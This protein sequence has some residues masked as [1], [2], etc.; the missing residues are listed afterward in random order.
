MKWRKIDP[1]KDIVDCII[2]YN[3]KVYAEPTFEMTNNG[4]NYKD[5]FYIPHCELLVIDKEEFPI[6]NIA[7]DEQETF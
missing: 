5:C 1:T 6:D 2:L 3:G 4:N 7:N